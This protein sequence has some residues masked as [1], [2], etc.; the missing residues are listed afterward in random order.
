MEPQTAFDSEA[1]RDQDSWSPRREEMDL[2]LR[3][4]AR[5][6]MAAE[7]LRVTEAGRAQMLAEL[8]STGLA[9]LVASLAKRY[10][11]E[12]ADLSW[13]KTPSLSATTTAGSPLTS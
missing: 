12:V 1:C 2:R 4:A 3:L 10:G 9:E 8:A 13:Q 11:L 5:L 6:L 7:G